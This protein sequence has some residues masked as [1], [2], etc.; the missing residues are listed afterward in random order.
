MDNNQGSTSNKI[1]E[2]KDKSVKVRVTIDS[3][4]AGHR[5]IERMFP[6]VKLERNSA[7]KKFAAANGEQI[8]DMGGRTILFK[9]N[10]GSTDA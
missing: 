3:G 4:D 9:T 7:P 1:N 5:V 8:R 6:R 2:V 10:E